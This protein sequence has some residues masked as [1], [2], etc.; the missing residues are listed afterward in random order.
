MFLPEFSETHNK[1]KGKVNYR[2]IG[3]SIRT[4]WGAPGQYLLK[5]S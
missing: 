3:D 4:K 1:S 2:K 5:R